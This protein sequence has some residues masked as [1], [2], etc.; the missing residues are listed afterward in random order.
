MKFRMIASTLFL[1][2]NHALIELFLMKF[3]S[4]VKNAFKPLK[5]ARTKLTKLLAMLRMPVLIKFQVFKL[6][7]L[8]KFQIPEII[9][10]TLE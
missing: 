9:F 5:L 8:M 2:A 10:L 7:A 6:F 1:I 4:I 3:H